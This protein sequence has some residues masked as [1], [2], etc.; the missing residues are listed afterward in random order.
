ML[1]K[2]F[3]FCAKCYVFCKNSLKESCLN[4]YFLPGLFSVFYPPTPRKSS[5]PPSVNDLHLSE[6]GWGQES[7]LFNMFNASLAGIWITGI[8]GLPGF[9]LILFSYPFMPQQ[10]IKHKLL[11]SI[12]SQYVWYIMENL[13]GDLL[14]GLKFV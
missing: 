5:G 7:H 12:N 14:L 2:I 10:L 4:L 8:M 3:L 13:A 6:S 11:I 9:A 1:S